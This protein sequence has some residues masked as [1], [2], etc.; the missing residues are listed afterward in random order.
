MLKLITN[1]F[2]IVMLFIFLSGMPINLDILDI[3]PFQPVIE[4]PVEEVAPIHYTLSDQS[5]LESIN[6]TSI[7]FGILSSEVAVPSEAFLNSITVTINHMDTESTYPLRNLNYQTTQGSD[8]LMTEV[9]IDLQEIQSNL[10]SGYY[11]ITI[12][13]NSDTNTNTITTAFTNMLMDKTYLGATDSE[14]NGQY[15]TTLFMPTKDYNLLVPISIRMNYPENRTR[16]TFNA[17]H[18]GVNASLGLMTTPTIPYAPRIYIKGAVA[19]VYFYTPE[20]EAFEQN[21]AMTISAITN[22]LTKFDYVDSVKYYINDSDQ[23]TFGGVDLNDTFT[24]TLQNSA[25]LGYSGDSAYLML[26]PVS[27]DAFEKSSEDLYQNIFQI[28][29]GSTFSSTDLEKGLLQT[30]PSGVSLSSAVQNG[31]NLTLTLSPNAATAYSALSDAFSKQ[32]AQVMIDSLVYTYTSLDGIDQVTIAIEGDT[33]Q[34][35]YGIDLSKPLTSAR[36]PNFL[37]N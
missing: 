13:S 30:V 33:S 10:S 22:T 4:A 25:Y 21:F 9:T 37:T 11:H 35:L 19:S 17:L 15:T 2:F 12:D 6:P 1:L 18:D 3:N 31:N 27:V 14:V 29:R 7:T 34:S 5:T 20:Q 26:T 28:L 24:S 32:F 23:L 16:A 8:P 36:Y